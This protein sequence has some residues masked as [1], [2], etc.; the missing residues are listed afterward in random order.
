M[1]E[2]TVL[3]RAKLEFGRRFTKNTEDL[4]NF[5]E[6][7]E[8]NAGNG[9]ANGGNCVRQLLSSNRAKSAAFL[10]I[11]LLLKSAVMTKRE[12]I[13]SKNLI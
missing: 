2:K 12:W 3:Q 10:D 6:I 13:E 1:L 4:R 7:E 5:D 9:A 11:P 8:N